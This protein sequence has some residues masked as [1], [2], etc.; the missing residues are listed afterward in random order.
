MMRLDKYWG[1]SLHDGSVPI[2]PQRHTWIKGDS[3]CSWL[4]ISLKLAWAPTIHKAQGLTLDEVV[5]DI[6]KEF[7]AGLTCGSPLRHNV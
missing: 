2:V 4:Q 3:A 7:S 1:P 6:G 5:I